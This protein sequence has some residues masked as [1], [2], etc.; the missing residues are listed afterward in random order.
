MVSMIVVAYNKRPYTEACLQRL[1]E[2][3]RR[4]QSGPAEII[5]V[6]NGSEDGTDAM[7]QEVAPEA[8]AAGLGFTVLR[9]NSNAGAPTARNQALKTAK[10]RYIAFVDN[11]VL[12]RTANW[13]APLRE[14]LES[15]NEAGIVGPKL[16]FPFEPYDIECAGRPPSSTR[17]GRCNA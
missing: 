7:L 6:D 4:A 13:L 2:A 17:P 12:V 11:D 14:R 16:V 15:N 10:G 9:N 3:H 1:L 8:E 5:V